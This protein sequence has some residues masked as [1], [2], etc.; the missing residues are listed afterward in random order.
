MD[1]KAIAI[2]ATLDTKGPEAA[3]VKERIE[4]SGYETLILDTGILAR[5]D[6][7]P[8]SSRGGRRDCAAGRE[9]RSDLIAKSA[10][11]ETR[12]EASGHGRG[13]GQDSETA[14]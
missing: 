12:T 11:K 5:R 10:E 13:F 6:P 2:I 8:G 1:K 3:F 14:L 7:R 9:D 4:S